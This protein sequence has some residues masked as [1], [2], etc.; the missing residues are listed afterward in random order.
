[1]SD[2]TGITTTFLTFNEDLDVG[3]GVPTR[4]VLHE[5][6]RGHWENE[7]QVDIGYGWER[8]MTFAPPR[9]GPKAMTSEESFV[10]ARELAAKNGPK[11][12]GPWRER[13][14]AAVADAEAKLAAE[15]LKKAQH[16]AA[17]PLRAAYAAEALN[18]LGRRAD[19]KAR[20]ADEA[21]AKM[22]DDPVLE[23]AALVP[24]T[25]RRPGG[26]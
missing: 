19:E 12:F 11:F 1:M 17:A 2:E 4:L 5:K 13:R 10:K 14:Q 18:E 21:A 9:E 8:V 15:R 23:G 3:L 7:L 22:P 6:D 16:D 24:R 20:Q 26:S 25:R